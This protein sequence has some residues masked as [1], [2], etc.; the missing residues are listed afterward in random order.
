MDKEA[1]VEDNNDKHD[2]ES[3]A[4]DDPNTGFVEREAD[5]GAG[6]A[7]NQ[8]SEKEDTPLHKLGGRR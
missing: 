1:W 3:D 5:A 4:N 8:V 2:Q 7:A 6:D